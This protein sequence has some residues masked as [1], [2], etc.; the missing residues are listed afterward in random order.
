MRILRDRGVNLVFDVGANVGQY[1]QS[2]RDYG[3]SKDI[4]SIEPLP[5]AWEV[6]RKNAAK[7][8]RWTVAPR[9]AVGARDELQEIFVSDNSVSSSLHPILGTHLDA[10]PR[11]RYVDSELVNV[12][13]LDTLA[14]PYLQRET[15]A[16]LKLD[17]QGH[18]GPALDGATSLLPK[19]AGL[20]I[21]LSLAPLYDGQA[22][23]RPLLAALDD[24][25]FEIWGLTPGFADPK[26]GRLLQFD[27]ILVRPDFPERPGS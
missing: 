2:L 1:A 4:L 16:F 8:P 27:A 26:S 24:A 18:E 14:D 6:L 20:Q 3:Y 13:R 21:E 19:L 5:D 10:E 7:D 9:C 11:S 23:Y 15:V 12:I 22:L 25:G 17:I